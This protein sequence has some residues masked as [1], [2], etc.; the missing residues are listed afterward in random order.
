MVWDHRDSFSGEDDPPVPFDWPWPATRA[1]VVDAFGQAQP[2]E[3]LDGRLHLRVSVTPL[4]V[5]AG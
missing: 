4:F 5:S 1:T 2:V 3:V